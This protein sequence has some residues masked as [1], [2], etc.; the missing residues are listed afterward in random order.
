MTQTTS[1][2]QSTSTSQTAS[3]VQTSPMVQVASTVQLTSGGQGSLFWPGLGA[4][5]FGM[6][7]AYYPSA[8]GRPFGGFLGFGAGVTSSLPPISPSAWTCPQTNSPTFNRPS[9]AGNSGIPVL[10]VTPTQSPVKAGAQL[11]RGSRQRLTSSPVASPRPNSSLRNSPP[12]SPPSRQLPP[13]SPAPQPSTPASTPPQHSP[14]NPVSMSS[15]APSAAAMSPPHGA[16][17]VSSGVSTNTVAQLTHSVPLQGSMGSSTTSS[18]SVKSRALSH[19]S[20]S[21]LGSH[22]W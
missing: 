6:P 18:M 14:Q 22:L 4:T 9:Q 8:E 17:A 19:S 15:R 2:T 12:P 10:A 11:A 3:V 16:S 13:V 20:H 7:R 21:Q 5:S 1:T